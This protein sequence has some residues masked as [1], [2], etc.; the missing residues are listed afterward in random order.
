MMYG[1]HK[2]FSDSSDGCS[3]GYGGHPPRTQGYGTNNHAPSPLCTGSF[4]YCDVPVGP[5]K[6]R[7][8]SLSSGICSEIFPPKL[9]E[10]LLCVGGIG[11]SGGRTKTIQQLF[12]GIWKVLEDR[13]KK[14][15]LLGKFI[16]MYVGRRHRGRYENI[17][18]GQ[19]IK[20]QEGS[21]DSEGK[22]IKPTCGRGDS[23]LCELPLQSGKVGE[24]S[25]CQINTCVQIPRNAREDTFKDLIKL[26]EEQAGAGELSRGPGNKHLHSCWN[27]WKR[28]D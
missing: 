28:K 16:Q 17:W 1:K 4:S 25:F 23:G 9:I 19:K 3:R 27:V 12:Q 8:L 14:S 26:P 5:P 13:Y 20:S 24:E 15:L 11:V 10:H 6:S 18:E 7:F 22:E 2:A 21:L